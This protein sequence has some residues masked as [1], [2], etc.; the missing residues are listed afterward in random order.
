MS[1][2]A[3]RL[4]TDGAVRVRV[5]AHDLG[6]GTYT[7]LGQ[8]AAEDLGVPVDRVSVSL[9]SSDL[10]IGPMSAGSSTTAS[11]GS[12]VRLACRKA[13]TELLA[14]ARDAA[15]FAGRDCGP[16]DIVG[17]RIVAADGASLA[18][19]ALVAELVNGSFEATAQ[20]T[21]RQLGSDQVA[22]ALD[23]RLAQAGPFS[24]THTMFSFGAQFAEVRVDPL[25]HRV[26]LGRLVGVFACG[27]IINPRTARSQL[28]G[29]MIWG[30]SHALMEEGVF[31]RPRTRFA[32]TD[33]AGYHFAVSADVPDITV[34][35]IHEDDDE[36]NPLGV[37]GVGETGVVGMAPA[38]ANAVHHATGIRVRRTPILVDSLLGQD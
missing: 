18:L 14:M 30:A 34:E 3:V 7:V 25:T 33:L 26:A 24:D 31:D 9:G 11:A 35:M 21:P 8:I 1:A 27:R 2:A 38:I 32:N 15:P 6:T 10:P 37:K 22:S 23:G 20:F 28:M 12:A 17:G 29:G 19:N 5:S 36:V 16:L 4:T 13:R